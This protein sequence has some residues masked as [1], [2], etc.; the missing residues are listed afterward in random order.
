MAA[1]IDQQRLQQWVIEVSQELG[2]PLRNEDD[3]FFDRGGDSL[4]AARLIERAEQEFGADSLPPD[5]L[6]D[7]STVREV[8]EALLLTI[9]RDSA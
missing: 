5:T 4:T 1:E 6:Y 9:A 3:D 8:A 7:G 2:V